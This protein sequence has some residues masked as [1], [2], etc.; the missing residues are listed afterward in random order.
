M[1]PG[2]ELD[3]LLQ[4]HLDGALDGAGKD[5]LLR[6]VSG[7][8]AAAGR[9]EEF[10]WI[11]HHLPGA[12]EDRPADAPALAGRVIG[13]IH[14][15]QAERVRRKTL[16]TLAARSRRRRLRSWALY[17]MAAAGLLAALALALVRTPGDTPRAVPAEAKAGAPDV[18]PPAPPDP[19]REELAITRAEKKKIEERLARDERLRL[20][21]ARPPDD[22]EAPREEERRHELARLEEN[23]RALRAEMEEVAERERKA[24]EEIARHPQTPP[25][26]LRPTVAEI[27]VVERVRGRVA[28]ETGAGRSLAPAGRRIVS[29]QGLEIEGAGGAATVRFPDGTS[30]DLEGDGASCG[31]FVR[32]GGAKAVS[33][34]RGFLA[35]QVTRQ[36]AG[37]PMVLTT[38][39]AETTVL[40]TRLTLSVTPD[41]TRLEVKSGKAR[42]RRPGDATA[43]DL[44]SAQ[45]CVASAEGRP[46]PRLLLL[47]GRVTP[48]PDAVDLTAEGTADW[49]HWG[50]EHYRSFNRKRN[51]IP[52]IGNYRK[53]GTGSI[54][55]YAN[56]PTAYRWTDGA[57]FPAVSDSSTG[58]YITGLDNGFQLTVPADPVPRTLKVY[59]GVWRSMGRFEA[60]LDEPGVPP[61]VDE[62]F[63]HPTSESNAVGAFDFRARGP[64]RTL[65]V[66]FT[67]LRNLAA[68]GPMGNVTLQAAALEIHRETR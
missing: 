47:S 62:S 65:R 15:R 3:P 36:P 56:S 53:V 57:P 60:V 4:D 20:E 18:L 1:T 38:P 31:I 49:A 13:E 5:V 40:G 67:M 61:F 14:R 24:R 17:G 7:D 41:S 29:G 42:L 27:A 12:I 44:T 34:A 6:A 63:G 43:V 59:V 64:G 22:P 39:H 16:G 48:A 33:L 25:V 23:L 2:E 55:R 46:A 68:S 9:L 37:R 21:L 50:L 45:F 51:V 10:L 66:R 19:A 58:I 35:A 30:L 32:D 54:Y 26:P 52:Q 8:P 28:L 11:H